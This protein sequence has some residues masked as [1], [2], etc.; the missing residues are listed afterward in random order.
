MYVILYK[1]K[2]DGMPLSASTRALVIP[3]VPATL[4]AYV[5]VHT[6]PVL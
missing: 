6:V 2:N 4:F 1:S 5:N 3:R